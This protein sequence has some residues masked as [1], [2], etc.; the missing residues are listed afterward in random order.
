MIKC[1]LTRYCL[2]SD[3]SYSSSF[4]LSPRDSGCSVP[5]HLLL[6]ET[7]SDGHDHPSF[8]HFIPSSAQKRT[9]NYKAKRCYFEHTSKMNTVKMLPEH[10]SLYSDPCAV[11]SHPLAPCPFVVRLHCDLYSSLGSRWH[12]LLSLYCICMRI[13]LI[14]Q[15]C[16]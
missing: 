7:K 9:E 4:L 1:L 8:L 6:L 15:H 3:P 2:V 16:N 5:C 13:T 10:M 11:P 14:Q 12:T